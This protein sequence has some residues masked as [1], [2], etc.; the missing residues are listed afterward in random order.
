MPILDLKL[1]NLGPFDDIQFAF[2]PQINLFVGPNN[3]GKSTV[4]SALGDILVYPFGLPK[5][6]LHKIPGEFELH[7]RTSPKKGAK[8]WSG[9]IPI[10]LEDKE[11]EQE[12]AETYKKIGFTCFIPALRRSTNYRSEGPGTG[13]KTKSRSLTQYIEREVFSITTH[14]E[15]EEKSAPTDPEFT[16]RS[17]LFASDPSLISDEVV[18]Q[19]L[20]DLDY[21]SYRENNPQLKQI[22]HKIVSIASEITE[23]YPITFSGN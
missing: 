3:S 21:K 18:I 12:V 5:K 4:L 22:I 11:I 15:K 17:R 14:K 23:G 10:N 16:R 9:K 19:K 6:Y 8:E 13:E 2:N 7:W 1:K 20:I